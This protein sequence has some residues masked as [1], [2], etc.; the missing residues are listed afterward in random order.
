MPGITY[1]C[2]FANEVHRYLKE[3]VN[4]EDFFSGNLIPDLALSKKA[5]HYR[6]SASVPGFFVP[7]MKQAKKE[8]FDRNNA[9]KL[10]MYCHLYFDYHFIEDYLIPSFLW[11]TPNWQVINPQN[12]KVWSVSEFFA[13][14]SQGGILYQGY[15]QINKL[16]FEANHI[17]IETLT[18]LPD[19]LP[20]TGLPVFDERRALT[21]REE[22]NGYLAEDIPYT[23]EILDYEALWNFTCSTASNFVT[24]ELNDTI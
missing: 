15:S 24:Q 7:N 16:M 4:K 1:H 13:K 9:I 8:L 6:I 23:G 20:I 12:G 19:E 3:Q 5:S 21:W 17:S 10:G 11:D 18:L 22:L 2:G 14:P